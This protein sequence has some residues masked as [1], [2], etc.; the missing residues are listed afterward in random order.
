L[1]ATRLGRV[2]FIAAVD[3]LLRNVPLTL[4]PSSFAEEQG[5]PAEF[6]N[7]RS[8]ALFRV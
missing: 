7:A 8:H 4:R 6:G 1:I 5:I 2:E 3:D